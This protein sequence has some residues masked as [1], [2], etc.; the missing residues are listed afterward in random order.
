MAEYTYKT[1]GQA[2]GYIPSLEL[3]LFKAVSEKYKSTLDSTELPSFTINLG[4]GGKTDFD[5]F[6]LGDGKFNADAIITLPES[7]TLAAM[8]VH[9]LDGTYTIG[10]TFAFYDEK[11]VFVHELSHYILEL[12]GVISDKY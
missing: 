10:H 11:S 2:F 6:P 4:S 7:N 3:E 5:E 1:L 8:P 9:T 12:L